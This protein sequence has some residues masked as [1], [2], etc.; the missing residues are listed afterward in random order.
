M[1][2][3]DRGYW[4]VAGEGV[5]AESLY[6][7][8]L[9]GHLDRPDPAS[10]SQ[11]QGVHGPSQVVDSRFPWQDDSWQGLPF[12]DYIIYEL[13][14]GVFTGEGTFDAVINHLDGLAD[15][16]ITAIE[17]MPVAQF[18]GT[19]N[20]GYDGVYPFAV[21]NSY[22]GP[23]GLKRLVN[24]CHQRGMAVVLDVVY[25]HVGPEGNYL[26]DFGPYFTAR[27]QT[28]WGRALN[29]DGPHSDEVRR[30]FVEN[31]LRWVGEFHVDALRLDALHAILDTSPHPF[32]E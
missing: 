26:E 11:P 29:F 2:R 3:R 21:Q 13:H 9:D 8:R 27:Y 23:Q 4:A 19:R 17:M 18:P 32:I 14:V 31:A 6:L 20:W 15:M 24:A 22:G 1:E 30:F 16:G 12:D 10:S 28:P 5:E 7:Y 25:N